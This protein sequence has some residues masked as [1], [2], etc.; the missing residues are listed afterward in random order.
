MAFDARLYASPHISWKELACKDY[1]HTPYPNDWREDRGRVLAAELERIRARC[2]ALR[3]VD[4]P[5]LITSAYRT[6]AHNQACRGRPRS[7]HLEGRA[8]DVQC[9][10]GL[11]YADFRQ[12]VLDAAQESDSRIRYLQFYPDQGF[13]HLDIRPI[14]R[15]IIM[16][17]SKD[18]TT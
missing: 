10:F 7:E 17:P 11:S 12:A 5:L 16:D 13:V 4:T 18:R 1:F 15:L 14:T 6:L 9:P 3:G 2:S 8:A